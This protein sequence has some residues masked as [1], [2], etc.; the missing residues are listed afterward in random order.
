MNK[1]KKVILGIILLI[2]LFMGIGY[3]ALTSVTLTINGTAQA[4]ANQENFKVYFTGKNSVPSNDTVA[5]TVQEKAQSANI[6]FN[7][8]T[9]KNEEKTAILEIKNDSVDI[10]AESITVAV[11]STNEEM[12]KVT[13]IM[14]DSEGNAIENNAVS[15]QSTTYVKVSTTLLKT[16]LT[17]DEKTEITATI[18]AVPKTK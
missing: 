6:Q 7:S 1:Q 18:T 17:D 3:A 2:V 8:F 14:C 10:D 4:S 11:T 13:A 12:F 9:V 16:P 15:A 5:I